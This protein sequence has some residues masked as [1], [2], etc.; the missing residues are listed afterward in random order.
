MRRYD[1]SNKIPVLFAAS[2][3]ATIDAK[4]SCR[5]IDLHILQPLQEVRAVAYVLDW[6]VALEHFFLIPGHLL[7]SKQE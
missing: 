6:G 2:P 4:V 5:E 3:A 7:L 1:R